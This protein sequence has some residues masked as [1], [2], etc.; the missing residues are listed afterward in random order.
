MVLRLSILT[1]VRSHPCVWIFAPS[2]E[3]RKS[4]GEGRQGCKGGSMTDSPPLDHSPDSQ[5][6]R[7]DVLTAET[8]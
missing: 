6:R 8:F 4:P 1:W 5:L 3:P 2:P 7:V